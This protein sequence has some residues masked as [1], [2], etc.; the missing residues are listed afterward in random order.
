MTQPDR[1]PIDRLALAASLVTVVLWAS[2]FVGIRA[3]SVDL[4]AGSLALGRLGV[5]AIA[6]GV[7]VLSRGFVRPSRRDLLLVVAS[8]LLWF[9]FYNVALNEAE[10]NVDAGTASM[11]TNLGPILIAIFAGVFL[12]EG[13]PP[14]LT[15][16]IAVAF[17]GTLVIGVASSSAPV[18]GGN[19]P[20]GI[21]LCIAAATAYAGGVT[22]QKPTLR[23][24]PPAQVTWMACATGAIACLPFLPTLVTDLGA[25]QPAS[26]AWMVYLGLF[27]TAIGFTTWAFALSRSSAG[28]LG[29]MT[30]LVPP[31]V[32][33][34]AW[35]LL[36]EVPPALAIAGGALCIA[37]VIVARSR[38]TLPWRRT[39]VAAGD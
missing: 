35:L 38:G 19:A 32:I 21:T 34:M 36:G 15:A 28:R 8:G 31:V 37:G 11:L 2:A 16:G 30:Y 14:R 22:L 13:F 9:A 27:P 33:G 10:R 29:S 23:A 17:I 39:L 12:H 1:A 6:L 5:G 26:I 3:A 7:L 20:L 4:S 18:A 25:A 24:L